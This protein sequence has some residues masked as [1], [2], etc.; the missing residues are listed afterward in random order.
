[1][2]VSA[3]H[4]TCGQI[5]LWENYE[6]LLMCKDDAS[7]QRE[8]VEN[9]LRRFVIFNCLAVW[10]VN[11]SW[12][13][14]S[15]LPI[16]RRVNKLPQ[17]I[18][19][20]LGYRMNLTKHVARRTYYFNRR[21]VLSPVDSVYICIDLWPWNAALLFLEVIL[22]LTK[23]TGGRDWR[24]RDFLRNCSEK[25]RKWQKF[26]RLFREKK[27][28]LVSNVWNKETIF[29]NIFW[30]FAKVERVSRKLRCLDHFRENKKTRNF[31]KITKFRIFAKMENDIFVSNLDG[32]DVFS[33]DF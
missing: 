15:T 17:N 21:L 31:F 20:A 12:S 6:T 9:W 5:V 14:N 28:N 32:S 10:S 1:M 7:R 22:K 27:A 16:T 11:F 2:N 18:W 13:F 25:I 29:V 24:G 8:G 4:T 19:V 26:P 30:F 3:T 33:V 23:R